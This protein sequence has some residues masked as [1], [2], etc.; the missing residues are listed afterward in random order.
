FSPTWM[1]AWMRASMT[2]WHAVT[3]CPAIRTPTAPTASTTSRAEWRRSRITSEEPSQQPVRAARSA[4]P[5][6]HR[7]Q[8]L[9]DGSGRRVTAARVLHRGR[10]LL[11]E[12]LAKLHAPLVERVD[13][14]YDALREH[15][16]LV[17]RDEPAESGRIDLLKQSDGARAAPGVDLVRDERL[18]LRR[19]QLLALKLR[20]HGLRRL[21]GH[22]G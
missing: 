3:C 18:E 16:V 6:L 10:Q 15:A 21:A 8:Q 2:A 22:E 12:L 17:E 11:G 5:F 19:R 13:A 20:A 7:C 1:R 14:P 4:A 9:H